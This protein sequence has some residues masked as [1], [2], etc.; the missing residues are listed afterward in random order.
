MMTQNPYAQPGGPGTGDFGISSEPPRTSVL[1]IF[2]LVL[3]FICCIPVLPLVG[4]ALGIVATLLI[5]GSGGKVAGRGLAIGAIIVGLAVTG[6][7]LALVFGA[8]SGWNMIRSYGDVVTYID[9]GDYDA[10]R[11]RFDQR[12]R[13]LVTDELLTEFSADLRAGAGAYVGSPESILDAFSAYASI[14]QDQAQMMNT[15]SA[16]HGQEMPAIPLPLEFDSGVVLVTPVFDPNTQGGGQSS[17]LNLGYTLQ[18]ETS[19]TW[20]LEPQA[21]LDA[22]NASGSAPAAVPPAGE[23]ATDEGAAPEAGGGETP[24]GEPEGAADEDSGEPAGEDG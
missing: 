6:L 8:A 5:T 1:A 12:V 11:D 14:G 16:A 7:Q 4:V 24:N 20:L 21:A 22:M 13:P 23:I 17:I 19:V 2:A 18:G 15:V 9:A 10:T 3:S